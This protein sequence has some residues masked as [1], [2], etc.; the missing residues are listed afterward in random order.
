[1]QIEAIPA[2]NQIHEIANQKL[3]IDPW[4]SLLIPSHSDFR[5]P[6][7]PL[8]IKQDSRILFLVMSCTSLSFD[9]CIIPRRYANQITWSSQGNSVSTTKYNF[10]TFLPKGLFEQVHHVDFLVVGIDQYVLIQFL[11]HQSC[12][13]IF[14]MC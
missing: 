10:F 2:L 13:I 14:C 7:D 4:V 5:K 3:F 6:N 8:C 12:L 1:M 11:W 9:L